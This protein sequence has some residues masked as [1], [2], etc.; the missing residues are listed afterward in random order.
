[1]AA[2]STI[3]APDGQ[4]ILFDALW[5]QM[6]LVGKG[7]ITTLTQ[8]ITV[9]GGINPLVA[10][11]PINCNAAI[12]TQGRSGSTFT[13]DMKMYSQSSGGYVDYW[14]YDKIPPAKP[15]SGAALFLLDANG[16]CTFSTARTPMVLAPQSSQP[17]GRIYAISPSTGPYFREQVDADVDTFGIPI[18][19]RITA[20][21]GWIFDGASFS[22]QSFTTTD[23]FGFS[24]DAV[25]DPSL[26]DYLVLAVTTH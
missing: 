12:A 15:T 16:N 22:I 5:P 20:V 1:M 10:F 2:I 3:W 11:R 14:I 17:A 26:S 24:S 4:R 7:R 6:V 13:Y 18:F 9:T 19:R 23:H 21:G 8:T 25:Y